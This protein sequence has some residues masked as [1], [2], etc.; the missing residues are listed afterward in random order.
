V[1]TADR[2][3]KRL[4]VVDFPTPVEP[5]DRMRIPR[6]FN[7]RSPQSRRDLASSLRNRDVDIPGRS[8]R[9][10]SEAADDQ[11]LARLRRELRAHPCHA[12]PDQ[13]EHARWAERL[14]R[15]ERETHQLERRVEN[16]TNTIA[17]TFDRVCALLTDMDYLRGDDVT[18]EGRR[19][20]RLYTELDLLVAECLREGLWDELTPPELAACASALVYESRQPDEIGPPRLPGGRA[21]A[22]LGDMVRLWSQLEELEKDHR[23]SFL[24]EPD[25][26]FAWAAHRWASAD[27]LEDV[28][29]DTELAAGDFVRWTKQLIDLLGQITSAAGEGNPVRRTADRAVTALRRGVVAYSSV[30]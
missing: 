21:R 18:P 9:P 4:S 2:Q 26:G 20:G 10:R 6:S 27:R 5:L 8:R 24:R 16:R 22:T 13:E 29:V 12:C 30:G 17:R 1:L 25:L 15:L 14:R 19:L 3:V 11:E 23:L 7:A 28:L